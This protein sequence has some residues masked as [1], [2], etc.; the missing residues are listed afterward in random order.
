M[1][2]W[3]YDYLKFDDGYVAFSGA[4]LRNLLSIR[5]LDEIR[6]TDYARSQCGRV[7]R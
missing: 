3:G 4:A 7:I 1:K 2:H 5:M 6:T